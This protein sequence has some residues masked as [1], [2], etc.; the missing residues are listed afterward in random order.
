MDGCAAEGEDAEPVSMAVH[1]VSSQPDL[2]L[3]IEL[4]E[5]IVEG[6]NSGGRP[7]LR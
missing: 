6:R 5:S 1:E 2:N 7:A 3:I 4:E